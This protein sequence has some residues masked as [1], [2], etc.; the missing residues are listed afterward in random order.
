MLVATMAGIGQTTAMMLGNNSS[1]ALSGDDVMRERLAQN[2]GNTA[3][4]QVNRLMSDERIIVT[5]AA[6]TEFYLVF[7]KPA[8]PRASSQSSPA[9]NMGQLQTVSA[10]PGR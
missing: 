7:T 2:M 10:I 1:A 8:L 5:L 3:D 4:S 6:G 9:T